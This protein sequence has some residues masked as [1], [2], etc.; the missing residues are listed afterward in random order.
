MNTNNG[1]ENHHFHKDINLQMVDVP[2]S[3]EFS[4]GYEES[5]DTEEKHSPSCKKSFQTIGST[6]KHIGKGKCSSPEAVAHLLG[7]LM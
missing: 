6:K 5:F 4:G 3:Y 1:L 2:L 7:P